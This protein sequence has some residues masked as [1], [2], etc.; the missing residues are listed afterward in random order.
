MR[1]CNGSTSRDVEY[2]DHRCQAD[3]GS[4]TA[5]PTLAAVDCMVLATNI[6]RCSQDW[7]VHHQG[8]GRSSV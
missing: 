3:A 2:V 1:S 6:S 8:A 4:G 5:E 7:E